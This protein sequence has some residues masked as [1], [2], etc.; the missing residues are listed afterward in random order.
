MKLGAATKNTR[1]DLGEDL[2]KGERSK[3]GGEDLRQ[4]HLYGLVFFWDNDIVPIKVDGIEDH[5]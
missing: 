5:E 4:G 1:E 3:M 2:G